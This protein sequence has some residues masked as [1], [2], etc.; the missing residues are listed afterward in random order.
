MQGLSHCITMINVPYMSGFQDGNSLKA[1]P[2]AH[3][4]KFTMEQALEDFFQNGRHIL[5]SAWRA[6]LKGNI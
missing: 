5:Q 2:K 3:R 6:V 1:W 4:R